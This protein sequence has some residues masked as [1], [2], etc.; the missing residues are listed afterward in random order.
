MK[1]SEA[2]FLEFIRKSH[3]F[4]V[5]IY[6]RTYSWTKKECEQLWND[7]IRAGSND[8]ITGHFVG[9]IVYV[10][11]D[12]SL[13]TYDS[14][15][16]LID[17]QQR[18]A[19]MILLITALY[20]TLITLPENQQEPFERFNPEILKQNYLINSGE[21]GDRQYKLI[22]S[23]TDKD[24]LISII[25]GTELPKNH[26][27]KIKE[28]YDY[29]RERIASIKTN[30]DV[31][32]KGMIKL[33]VVDTALNRGQDNP[34]LIFESMN[35]TGKELTQT[36]LIR[37]FIL[38]GLDQEMQKHLYEHYW[39][40]M[41]LDFG[42]ENYNTYF[43]GFIRHYLTLKNRG[44]IPVI[45][46][47]YESF[48]E[49]ARSPEIQ[50]QGVEALVKEIRRFSRY[51]CTMAF[52]SKEIDHKLDRA[53]HDLKELRSD[54]T[55]PLLLELY[56]DYEEKIL[57]QE[58]F[59]QMIQL[60]ES[61]IFR[62]AVCSIPTNSLNLTFARMS[63]SLDKDRYLESMQARM[64]LLP[65]Y[66]RFP[67][68]EEFMQ[69]IQKR[70]MYNAARYN[71]WIRKM[72]N[73]QHKE[74][75]SVESYTVEHILPQNPKLSQ[76]WRE[77]L[78]PEWK[79][80]QE[81]WLHTLGNLTLTG[82]NPE[83]SDRTFAEKRDMPGGFKESHIRLNHELGQLDRWDE[84]AIKDRTY[85]LSQ[86]ACEIWKAPHVD[87]AILER[88]KEDASKQTTT[89]TIQD[90]PALLEGISKDLF[91]DL[92]TRIKS[93]DPGVVTE[94]F[95]KLYVAY[96]AETN[97]VDII[98]QKKRL[99]LFLNIPFPDIED[100]KGI[101]QNVA[102]KKRWGNGDV[103]VN[104]STPEEIPYIMGL[105][106]QAYERQVINGVDYT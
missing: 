32:C 53:F 3:Q 88:Y 92:R 45:N 26:S 71:Y 7:I 56:E 69:E 2:K 50:S 22:L 63:A 83:Y 73:H 80:I 44:K 21:K 34:Q 30:L 81:T 104:L 106:R 48:K 103:E 95:L 100:P 91:E 49:Y 94:E 43:D 10:E 76:G 89:F 29:F 6:Q 27:I 102:G 79:R 59:L 23:Q 64:L 41:E 61:Y 74:P 24:T 47:V 72:E 98:P 86:L 75:V 101:G 35:S 31:L 84:Q 97:F 9:S 42:Q 52:G 8:Q 19:T 96:K 4:K 57:S 51:Y 39:R 33:I 36:D 38:M 62:R 15:M 12:L 68:D 54:V 55:Y 1:A 78:G 13:I 105:I 28:N 11:E 20:D 67:T 60:I 93:L 70:D 5:P 87:P 25:K 40:P 58:D 85:R 37:N 66:R 90:H 16:F 65:S 82:Y 18:L 17:G 77:M 46:R 99:I 14:P